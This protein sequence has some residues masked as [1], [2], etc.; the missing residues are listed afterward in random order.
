MRL[1]EH[2]LQGALPDA[3][4]LHG[5]FPDDAT[6][7]VDTRTLELGDIFIALEGEH[8]DGHQY[9]A[10][11]LRKGASGLFISASKKDVLASLEP[12]L[13]RGKLVVLANNV[14]ESF[15]RLASAWRAQF[16]YPV[17]AITGSVGKTSTKQVLANILTCHGEHV[18]VSEGNQNT[19][20]G[21]GLNMLRMRDDH[22]AAIFEVGISKR[23]EMAQLAGLLRP[24]TALITGIGHCHMEGLGSLSDIAIEK[25]D[26]FKY[27]T[28]QS[29]GVVN[30]DQA[31]LA[32]VGY[33]HPIIKFGSK[34]TNQI[35]ARKI[36]IESDH[37][38]FVLKIYKEKY[39]V[40]LVQ[41]HAGAVF[42]ALGATVLAHY[43][44][45]P[46]ATIL[47]GIQA[48]LSVKSR[49]E[50]KELKTG[51][52]VMISDCYNANPESMKAALL[53]FEQLSTSAH[54]IAVLGDMLE[55]GVNSPFWHRQLGRFLRKVPSLQEVILVGKMVEWTKKTMPLGLSTQHVATWEDAVQLLQ[56]KLDNDS[57][58]LVKG[59]NGMKLGNL[60][61]HFTA[62]AKRHKTTE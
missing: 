48:P 31:V 49:F 52:G 28:E 24:T 8:T 62:D 47:E 50:H 19:R 29:I 46:D 34:T 20:I 3:T 45:V 39:N 15:V 51:H 12:V 7:C 30:G 35:Q 44:G 21:L 58:V 41:A 4:I 53:A 27:F 13:L 37:I 9:L 33:A 61:E 54:K 32:A 43:L 26:V 2:F 56:D 57:V 6:F 11:A 1:D 18:M 40:R 38:S 14:L 42:N 5:T 59:S 55:L 10:D 17:V 25:R 23:G 60:V 22:K 16:E 36:K